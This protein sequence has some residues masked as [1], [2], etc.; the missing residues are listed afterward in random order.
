[1]VFIFQISVFIVLTLLRAQTL[2]TSGVID[3]DLS[4]AFYVSCYR[5]PCNSHFIRYIAVIDL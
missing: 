2:I 4:V 1:M 5:Q 3:A